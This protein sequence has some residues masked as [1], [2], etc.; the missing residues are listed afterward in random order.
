MFIVSNS[1]EETYQNYYSSLR[2]FFVFH[3]CHLSRLEAAAPSIKAGVG[4]APSSLLSYIAMLTTILICGV[5]VAAANARPESVPSHAVPTYQAPARPAPAYNAPA[6]DHDQIPAQY[7]FTYDAQD[8]YTGRNFGHQE[9][10][11]GYNTQ[12]SYY[13]PLADGRV[14]KV[15]YYVDGDS[16]FVAEIT[17]EGTATYPDPAPSY[18][19][20]PTYS[21]PTPAPTYS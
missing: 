14:Q 1:G 8:P 21:Q 11:D 12:G 19:P 3:K 15:T 13:V 5:L 10:R 20:K 17:Y 16:G 2:N 6:P 9:V 4:V 18:D 7:D